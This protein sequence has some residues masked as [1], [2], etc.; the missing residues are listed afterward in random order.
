M[1]HIIV[2]GLWSSSRYTVI[3][4]C[5]IPFLIY[6]CTSIYYFTYVLVNQFGLPKQAHGLGAEEIGTLSKIVM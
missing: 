5:F 1:I 3:I 2:D 4:F 6:F